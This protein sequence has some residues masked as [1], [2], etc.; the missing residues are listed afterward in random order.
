[1]SLPYSCIDPYEQHAF[2]PIQIHADTGQI[3]INKYEIRS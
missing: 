2:P 3:E 1:M